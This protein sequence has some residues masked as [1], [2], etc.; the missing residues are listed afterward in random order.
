MVLQRV[1]E[2][3]LDI[4]VNGAQQA[5]FTQNVEHEDY[6]VD[7]GANAGD[8]TVGSIP[9]GWGGQMVSG[10]TRTLMAVPSEVSHGVD[11]FTIYGDIHARNGGSGSTINFD[12][13]FYAD[14]SFIQT[15]S[16]SVGAGSG[17][18]S[19]TPFSISDSTISAGATITAQHYTE[20][21]DVEE[22]SGTYDVTTT[23]GASAYVNGVSTQ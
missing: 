16:G 5:S 22:I 19:T 10:D 17:T 12:I 11:G 14:G 20:Y 18:T 6:N 1:G 3:T 21:L 13:D 9:Y 2:K 8:A 7:V 15:V 4:L 23:P